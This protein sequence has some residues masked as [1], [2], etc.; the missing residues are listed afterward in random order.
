[1]GTITRGYA[2]LITADGPNAVASG[3]IQ[4]ADLAAGVIGVNTPAF[5]SAFQA[6]DQTISNN[7]N[8]KVV[9]STENFDTDSKYDNAT[10]YRFTPGTVGKYF[11]YADILPQTGNYSFD[12]M[13]YKNGIES[14]KQRI[15]GVTVDPISISV[16][17][18]VDLTNTT[19]YLEVYCWQ[20]SGSSKIIYGSSAFGRFGAYR[21]IGV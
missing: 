10:N 5:Q 13:I 15:G 17:G 3:S 19:D 7:T 21:L 14:F 2:N 16:H 1:M 4:A 6:G 9:F 20:N 8:T 18:I 11:V 12:V